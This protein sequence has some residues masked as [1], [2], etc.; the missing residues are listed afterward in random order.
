MKLVVEAWE[1]EFQKLKPLMRKTALKLARFLNKK[2]IQMEIHLVGTKFMDKNVL[3]FPAPE[4]FPRPDVKKGTKALGEIY[5]N[6]GY[7]EKH[8]ENLV[9]MLIHGFL[10]LLGYDHKKKS[11]RIIMEKREQELLKKL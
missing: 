10:H 8:D 3:S 1:R 7:I 9:Y 4:G 6:P 2:D 5:L 11:D